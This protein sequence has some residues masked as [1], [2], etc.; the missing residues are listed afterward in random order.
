MS[1]EVVYYGERGI[2]NSI[3]LD[4]QGDI[5]KQKQFLRTIVLGDKSKL[6]WVDDV[7][8]V[9]YFVEPCFDQ[10]GK[11]DL[12]IEATTKRNDKYIL[13]VI[14]KFNSYE[15][16]ALKMTQLKEID[17]EYLPKSYK[18]SGDN[19]NVQLAVLYRFIQAYKNTLEECECINSIIIESPEVSKIYNDDMVRQ[20]ENWT[21][22]EYWNNN[23]KNV[24]DYYFVALTNDSKQI[25]ENKNLKSEYFPFNREEVLPPITKKQWEIDSNKF[26][27]T[28]FD[29]LVDKNVISKDTGYYKDSCELMMFRPPTIADYKKERESH[30]LVTIN[31]DKWNKNQEILYNLLKDVKVLDADFKLFVK[32]FMETIEY[33]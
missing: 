14:V 10:F 22:L 5:A 15:Y 12:I 28:T 21:M 13:F 18:S 7:E 20:F 29:T 25:I 3:V 8:M 1:R 30:R 27:I 11:V 19:V 16:S 17:N 26:G 9:K 24:K 6:E 23:F 4:T 31:S 33:E 2:L 32:D